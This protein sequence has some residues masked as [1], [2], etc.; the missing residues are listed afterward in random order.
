[1]WDKQQDIRSLRPYLIEEAYEVLEQMDRIASGGSFKPLRDELGDLLFQIVFHAQLASEAGEFE[2][3]DV[4]Q[5]IADKIEFRHPHVF[6][7]QKAAD[8]AEVAGRW[9]KLKAEERRRKTG[10]PGSVIDGVPKDAPALMRA[11]RLTEKA[12]RVGFDWKRLEDVRAK[13]DEEL[14]ELDEAITSGESRRVE[15]E[16]G[17]VLFALAN[18]GRFV[19][20]HPEDALRGAID[21]FTRRFHFIEDSLRERGLEPSDVTLEEMDALWNEAKARE[22]QA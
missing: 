11:E 7:D 3:A 21:R 18:L 17:D 4:I 5:A 10:R 14:G 16:L 6:G 12:S 13:L 1:P 2:L 15:E 9:V 19:E 20:V 8:A 22:R